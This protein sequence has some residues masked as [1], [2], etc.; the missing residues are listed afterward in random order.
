METWII[1]LIVLIVLGVLFTPSEEKQTEPQ[2]ISGN[3]PDEVIDREFKD[4][5]KRFVDGEMADRMTSDL[6]LRKDEYLIFDIPGVSL[7]EERT[8]KTKGRTGSVRVRVMKGVSVGLGGFEAS[9]ETKVIPIDIGNF[10]LTNKR[11][12]YSGD[13]KTVDFALNKINTIDDLD[14]GISLSRTGK[15]KIEYYLDTDVMKLLVTINPKKGE[16]FE[17]EQVAYPINGEQCKA[18]IL[19]A[20]SRQE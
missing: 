6:I 13:T 1:I 14:S 7:C 10:I 9:P 12:H 4:L 16:D 8:I 18:I 2:P 17:S 15:S 5:Q 20:I 19:E 11:I 3:I